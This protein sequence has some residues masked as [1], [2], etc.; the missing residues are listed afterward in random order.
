MCDQNTRNQLLKTDRHLLDL[1]KGRRKVPIVKE[2]PQEMKQTK[3]WED[4]AQSAAK[5]KQECSIQ[6]RRTEAKNHAA[7]LFEGMILK[8]RRSW[9][10]LSKKLTTFK[11]KDKVDLL[12]LM[13]EVKF[14]DV[15]DEFT[16]TAKPLEWSPQDNLLV[17]SIK[18]AADIDTDGQN[19]L[20]YKKFLAQLCMDSTFVKVFGEDQ[21]NTKHYQAA[22]KLGN[23]GNH[24]EEI[25]S[26]LDHY[27]PTQNHIDVVVSK[28]RSI[29]I[30]S[31][32]LRN[33]RRT[34]SVT[35]DEIDAAKN[36][37][38]ELKSKLARQRRDCKSEI[39]NNKK[40]IHEQQLDFSTR[41]QI[42]GVVDTLITSV[43]EEELNQS[44][45]Q[46]QQKQNDLN[47]IMG[48]KMGADVSKAIFQ[49]RKQIKDNARIKRLKDKA[50]A[51]RK[52][53][54]YGRE[55]NVKKQEEVKQIQQQCELKI[56]LIQRSCEEN[57]S[58]MNMRIGSERRSNL[59]EK[60]RLN[61]QI[62]ELEQSK[63]RLTQNYTRHV[64]IIQKAL[65]TSET[66]LTKLKTTHQSML[67]NKNIVT[68]ERDKLRKSCKY[69]QE[70]ERKYDEV[71]KKEM[72]DR[73]NK[74]VNIIKELSIK[75]D[76][77]EKQLREV[78]EKSI[79]KMKEKHEKYITEM[80]A[81]VRKGTTKLK[82]ERDD[83][84]KKYNALK[85]EFR[86]QVQEGVKE[87]GQEAVQEA[88]Q[89]ATQKLRSIKEKVN[90]LKLVISR[91]QEEMQRQKSEFSNRTQIQVQKAV[92]EMVD[93]LR[94]IKEKV[95][96]L[97]LVISRQQEKMDKQQSD[98]SNQTQIQQVLNELVT[99]VI[100][101]VKEE[102]LN[103][104]QQTMISVNKRKLID[105][106]NSDDEEE[107]GEDNDD[108]GNN[109]DKSPSLPSRKRT[110]TNNNS[111]NPEWDDSVHHQCLKAMAGVQ[112]KYIDKWFDV[113]VLDHQLPAACIEQNSMERI[114]VE[115]NDGSGKEWI[116]GSKDIGTRI[117]FTK[118]F[119]QQTVE[120]QIK[121]EGLN[122]T[123]LE[124]GEDLE[125][126]QDLNGCLIQSENNKMT[127]IDALKQQIKDLQ[128]QVEAL[129]K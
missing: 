105:L 87:A 6:Q 117:K 74:Y 71:R 25:L 60:N 42:Q 1:W 98:F 15:Q 10:S 50:E 19:W 39:N 101:N 36:Q 114:H 48:N 54:D 55:I 103:L 102:E 27:L 38:A 66:E 29:Q 92:Q 62:G 21:L 58:S 94:S 84:E 96:D 9:I 90:D 88:V 80:K 121:I 111:T 2:T 68:V 78:H 12:W 115:Y 123:M 31:G 89:T 24:K 40:E 3:E 70:Q 13:S 122:Q 110:R 75:H 47:Y 37:V 116:T 124:V 69:W 95:N 26:I 14:S 63:H 73:E 43:I 81:H 32:G 85:K 72:L 107:N 113:E 46:M 67:R 7:D 57:I 30:S 16:V 59:Y 97:K 129:K 128:H 112:A 86:F 28:N 8:D 93:K 118:S 79:T 17:V 65:D 35:Q 56:A 125:D 52:L 11:K 64:N 109:K 120:K 104:L 44:I 45:D 20:D 127:E 76:A 108:N 23:D 34:L 61:G 100:T 33:I 99:N 83:A 5:L 91:Q 4:G 22:T 41:T 53:S 51:Q 18:C 77:H 49:L 119:E 82:N 126:A 106:S